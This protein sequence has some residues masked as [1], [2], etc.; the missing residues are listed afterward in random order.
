V[1]DD[2]RSFDHDPGLAA[3]L[4]AYSD[5]GVGG[6][7]PGSIAASAI[8]ARDARRRSRLWQLPITPWTRRQVSLRVALGLLLVA[9]ALVAIVGAANRPEQRPIA[10]L[11]AVWGYAPDGGGG[12]DAI[13]V[14]DP[15]GTSETVFASSGHD[16]Y[17]V[18]SPDGT[19]IAYTEHLGRGPVRVVN[20]D[21]TGAHAITVGYASSMPVA[22]SPDSRQIAFVGARYPGGA[23]RGLHVV[24]A[25][26][27]GLVRLGGPDGER[28]RLA[29]SPDGSLIAFVTEASD[30]VVS[31]L[32]QVHVIDPLTNVVTR[33]SDLPFPWQED[34]AAPSWSGDGSRL[35]FAVTGSHDTAAPGIA[36]ARRDLGSWT[37]RVVVEGAT[38]GRPVS[39][40]WL[41][42]DRFV[43]ARGSERLMVANAD[44][45]GQRELI[46][47]DL[48]ARA[49]PCV[50]PDGS[51]VAT[52]LALGDGTVGELVIVGIDEAVPTRR[53]T[54][55]DISGEGPSC[56][57]QALKP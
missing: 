57:W 43:F 25:D 49:A 3:L 45:S 27:T 16:A 48:L 50:A 32:A 36:V 4:R 12:I 35:L 37:E 5:L 38:G 17:P 30:T 11:I 53:I 9:A 47:A 28:S 22:W 6:F 46:R 31:G 20:A 23:D 15:D 1:S 2:R 44:G 33:V 10:G 29:W 21:G 51:R 42:A 24:N 8:A 13:R 34:I 18:W 39:P 52:A 55:G 26:G 54:T 19:R 56:S 7:D 40:M 41:D 14:I